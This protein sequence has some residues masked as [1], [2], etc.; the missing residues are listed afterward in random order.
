MQTGTA[1]N[2]ILRKY[3]IKA[4]LKEPHNPQQNPVERHIKTIKNY[5]S[6]IMDQ[7]GAPSETWFLCLL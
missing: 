2:D 4:K 7:T 1:W 3:S 5:T 6:K